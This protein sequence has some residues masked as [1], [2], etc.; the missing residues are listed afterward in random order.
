ML[1]SGIGGACRLGS[2]WGAEGQSQVS[3]SSVMLD[4]NQRLII[5]IYTVLSAKHKL[6][7]ILSTQTPGARTHDPR[8]VSWGADPPSPYSWTRK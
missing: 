2:E 3:S 6:P 4:C 7:T 5:L 8:L 1:R